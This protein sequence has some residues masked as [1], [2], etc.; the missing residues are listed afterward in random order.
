MPVKVNEACELEDIWESGHRLE[1]NSLF[2]P[3]CSWGRYSYEM[4]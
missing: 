3:F 2:S 1:L 4:L